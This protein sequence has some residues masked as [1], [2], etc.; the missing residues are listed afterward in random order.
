M[1]FVLIDATCNIE[2]RGASL[3]KGQKGVH[4]DRF[5]RKAEQAKVLAA[6]KLETLFEKKLAPQAIMK[7]KPESSL[8]F[9]EKE[10]QRSTTGISSG[11]SVMLN[12]GV[13]FHFAIPS[14]RERENP[15]SLCE[16]DFSRGRNGTR[17]LREI[18]RS[19]SRA[20]NKKRFLFKP[21]F[22]NGSIQGW[23]IAASWRGMTGCSGQDVLQDRRCPSEKLGGKVRL[24]C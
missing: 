5:Q 3:G 17:P 7:R 23:W 19:G 2:Q 10:S 1:C 11:S 9:A 14:N 8:G 12:G 6:K 16:G 18:N 21:P 15:I 20:K 13:R 22:S 24:V 4:W